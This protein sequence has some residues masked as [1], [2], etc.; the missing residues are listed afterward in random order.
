MTDKTKV[1]ADQLRPGDVLFPGG[2]TVES[3]T[4][5]LHGRV[6]VKTRGRQRQHWQLDA[7]WPLVV[8]GRVRSDPMAGRTTGDER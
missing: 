1:R 4:P 3:V 8:T 6:E 2:E 7:S 5:V